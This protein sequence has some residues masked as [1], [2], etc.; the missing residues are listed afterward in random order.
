VKF[1]TIILKA[2]NKIFFFIWIAFF[3]FTFPNPD[4]LSKEIVLQQKEILI[5][6]QFDP[7]KIPDPITNPQSYQWKE[8]SND[9]FLDSGEM[10]RTYIVRF[11]VPDLNKYQNPAF[12]IPKNGFAISIFSNNEKI[13]SFAD[14]SQFQAGKF[15]GWPTHICKFDKSKLGE[16]FYF[17]VYT[18]MK[19]IFPTISI[20]EENIL[21]QNLFVENLPAYF[22]VS[23]SY[24]LGLGFLIAFFIKRQDWM[25]FSLFLF[26]ISIGTWL[27]N[28]NP[29]AHYIIPH[30]PNRLKV[31]YFSLYIAPIGAILFLESI[32]LSRTEI[33]LRTIRY[34][35]IVYVMI[36]F[37]LDQLGIYPLWKTL[38]PFDITLLFSSLLYTSI[39]IYSSFKGKWEAKILSVGIVTLV[40][41]AVHDVLVVIGVFNIYSALQMHWGV[42][43]FI[44]AMSGVAIYRIYLMNWHIKR[45][46][47][48]LEEK[49]IILK[50]M[51]E[52]KEEMNQTLEIK[53]VERTQ[54]IYEMMEKIKE[55]K[56]QQD[57]D[58][59]LT[60]LIEKPLCKII[61]ESH[62]ISVETFTRQKKSFEF[63]GK[64]WELGG[65]IIIVSNLFFHS[66]DDRY[67]FFFNGDAMGK[68]M[69]G[70]GGAIVAGTAINN[71]LNRSLESGDPLLK[72]PD[73]WLQD[74]HKELDAIF[75]TFDGSMLLSC[76]LGLVR[77]KDGHVLFFNAEHPYTILY[78]DCKAEF[79]EKSIELYKLGA[80]LRQNFRLESLFLNPG[81]TILIGSDGKDDIEILENDSYYKIN[82][83]EDLIL[84]IVQDSNADLQEI[85]KN[86]EK[87]GRFTDDVSLL[88]IH[89]KR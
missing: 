12:Y 15:M 78:K 6:D 86:L 51:N 70:A 3:L 54:E 61:N 4:L 83:E 57:A 20:E 56:V 88:K 47:Q 8:I 13:F 80:G 85:I 48:E 87:I 22:T 62:L 33:I 9:Y 50:L 63:R 66:P 59:F 79:I 89:Y 7:E 38:F 68:S 58:Y 19:I 72:K 11:R 39:I 82:Q 49:N 75:K 17:V 60:T 46:S 27:F 77:E 21:L 34:F 18:E 29:I 40:I 43:S 52:E 55:L 26:F 31:E 16:Y 44:L 14:R 81:D 53:V 41:F 1:P 36:S 45:Y 37:F 28:I 76:T 2:N 35:Y 25:Y 42:L 69:Q 10:G 24:F 67:V 84:R 30:S 71:I 65:D 5:L 74:V 64:K 32:I 73:I 23:V